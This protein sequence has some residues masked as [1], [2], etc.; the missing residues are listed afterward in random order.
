MQ[1]TSPHAGHIIK[2]RATKGTA[3]ATLPPSAAF[4]SLLGRAQHGWQDSSPPEL[5]LSACMCPPLIGRDWTRPPSGSLAG[6]AADSTA[7]VYLWQTRFKG[8]P[9]TQAEPR[10][11]W[12]RRRGTQVLVNCNYIPILRLV[13]SLHKV[14]FTID[15]LRLS[16]N[17]PASW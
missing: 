15:F 7:K 6:R 17:T 12:M 16:K 14:T 1:K 5:K 4:S 10:L 9:S 13:R 2:A 3:R 11:W 8:S